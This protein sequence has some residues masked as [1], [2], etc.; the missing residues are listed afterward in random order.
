[1]NDINTTLWEDYVLAVKEYESNPTLSN[2]LLAIA[3]FEA[4]FSVFDKQERSVQ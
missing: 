2:L 4:F 1:M 3:Q